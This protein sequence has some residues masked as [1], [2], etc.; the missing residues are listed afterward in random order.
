MDIGPVEEVPPTDLS[1]L[2]GTTEQLAALD[3]IQSSGDAP[4]L[5]TLIGRLPQTSDYTA[6]RTELISKVWQV[7]EIADRDSGLRDQLNAMAADPIAGHTCGDGV[8]LQFNQLEVQV[9]TRET[10]EGIPEAD[11][12]AALYE[13]MRALYRLSEVDRLAVANSVNR[14]EAEVRLAYRLGLAQRLGLPNPPRGMLFRRLAAV[15]EDELS[16]VQRQV[17]D[18]ERGPAFRENATN[19]DIWVA[20]LEEAYPEAFAQI[21]QTLTAE[22]ERLE[23][24][25]PGLGDAYNAR[26]MAIQEAHQVRRK[27]LLDLL[28]Y[29]EGLK[30]GG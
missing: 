30:Y 13:R 5:M 3:R 2:V 9:V 14:D 28:T 6:V 11:R 15:N 19:R 21:E 25:F 18:S 29:Q 23:D 22:R 4:M 24:E 27:A 1:W 10:L 16:S 17:L 7:L 8:R 26:A 20:W 12:G